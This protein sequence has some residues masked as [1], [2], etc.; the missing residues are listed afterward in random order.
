M[1]PFSDEDVG[2]NVAVW[3]IVTGNLVRTFPM[4][5]DTTIPAGQQKSISWPMFKWSP[6]EKYAARVTPGQQISVYETPSLGM[7]GKKSIKIEGV[8]DFE[9][10]PMNDAEREALEAERN[11]SKPAGSSNLTN[12]LAFWTPEITN[13]PARVSLMSLPSRQILRSKN[14]FNVHDCKLHWQSQGDYLCVKVDRHTKTGKTRYCNLE[15]FRLREKDIPVQVIE[16]KG[17][18][19]PLPFLSLHRY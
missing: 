15:L 17:A 14:L 9:W 12:K 18:L 11:G 6:D 16:I 10:A 5:V 13:Q 7:L 19:L 3:D 8:I 2:N 1:S 4:V